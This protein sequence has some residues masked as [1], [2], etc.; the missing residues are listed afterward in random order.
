MFTLKSLITLVGVLALAV[1]VWFAG[2]Y[3]A[4]ADRKILEE[5]WPRLLVI[6]LLLLAWALN[7]LRLW[8]QAKQ[9]NRQLAHG[10]TQQPEGTG[11]DYGEN[12]VAILSSRFREAVE[13]LKRTSGKQKH[14]S[15]NY[16]YELPWY[17]LIGPPGSGKTTALVNSG[18]NF[19]LEEKFGRGAVKGVGGTRHCDWW[20]TD[21]A[22]LIDTAGR[23]TTQDSHS[24]ADAKAWRGF[25]ALLK[26]YR[27]RRPINGVLIAMGIDELRQQTETELATNVNAIRARL[28]ELT[29]TLGV[30]FPV[31]LLL[32]KCD[33]L[34]GFSQYFDML[35]KEERAQV[36]G[37]TL[38]EKLD[39]LQTCHQLF[40]EE[41]DLLARRL[42]DNV[43][44]KFH[45]ERDQRRRAAI[46]DFPA[47]F[48][49]VKNP[50]GEFIGRTF[51]ESRF[52]DR[53][54]LR[55][56]YFT[57]GTQDGN[58]MQ[59]MLNSMAGRMGVQQNA[60][61][62]GSQGQGKSFFIRNLFQQIIFPEAEMVGV[63]RRHESKLRWLQNAG[64]VATLGGAVGMAALWST[65]YGLNEARLRQADEL[66]SDYLAQREQISGNEQPEQMLPP[67]VPLLALRDV[68]APQP[69]DWKLGFGLD[70]G[71]P[72]RD[73]AAVEYQNLLRQDFFHS[74]QNQLAMQLRQNQDQPEYLHQALKAYLMLSLPQ[75]LDK[76][77]VS[78]WL[79]ADWQNRHAQQPERLQTLNT[80][81]DELMAQEWPVQ[82]TDD[83]LVEDTRRILKQ[84]PLARQIY[85]SIKEKARQQ[86][87]LDFRFDTQVGHNIHYVFNGEY[88]PI[89]WLYTTEGYHDFFKPQQANIIEQ[90]ADDS[91][92]VGQR[93]EDM[94]DLDLATVQ[95][96]VEKS[97]LDDYI[98]HWNGAFNRL[99]IKQPTS[100]DDQVR[101]LNELVG[102][103]SPLRRVL[104][105]VSTHTQ[106]SKPLVDTQALAQDAKDA[107]ALAGA[108]NGAAGS[109]INSKVTRLS[110]IA[111]LASR[112][113]LI[114]LPEN[115][116]TLVDT[117]FE[118]IHELMTAKNN[119]P[120]PVERLF[121]A[122][123]EVQRFLEG[124]SSSGSPQ[125]ASYDLAM[126]R[127]ANGRSDPIGN[128]KIEARHLP[129]PVQQWINSLVDR[130]WGHVLGGAGSQ[131]AAEYQNQV[132]PFYERSLEGRYPFR[133]D[134]QVEV[135]LADF[136]EFFKPGGIQDEFF[137]QYVEP[138]VDTKRSPWRSKSVDGQGLGISQSTLAQFEQAAL[139][140]KVFFA[141]GDAPKVDFKL[142]ATYLDANINRFEF[143][144]LGER[145]ENRHGPARESAITWPA[146]GGNDALEYTFEDH[147]GVQFSDQMRGEWALFRFLDRH[148]LGKT[149][150]G[151]RFNLVV[152]N[153]ERK[154]M[155]ELHAG[156]ALNPFARDYLGQ[157]RLPRSL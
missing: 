121:T 76:E 103:D 60:V 136:A 70:Q 155:Y 126:G 64:Y 28:Q 58:G 149:G 9:G 59:R 39:P 73:L 109:A 35:G 54:L 32:T 80:R 61:L 23:Y 69:G 57:S 144:V 113:R 67:F 92:V 13:I 37:M 141:N 50:A 17:I 117:R 89:P 38:P 41:F 137:K 138:F 83:A 36:W 111:T 63:N 5:E 128:L 134:A 62:G 30:N 156:S 79:K 146:S 135:T 52:H 77:F 8:W 42:H 65:S 145:M 21:Q 43:L 48:E 107:G 125:Q 85:V 139:I 110:R 129:Q 53:F 152:Q 22:V 81:L 101:L 90:L 119:A 99:R 46:L 26:K 116:A 71:D 31:Y 104:E 94:S 133:K 2:P 131:M 78:A 120:A 3:I 130:A 108:I 100:L 72:V 45:V 106:L 47:G 86:H 44:G 123:N 55:G 127:M 27:K 34:P 29:D 157:F 19:P 49:Q 122:L 25:I 112:N 56:V 96:A 88:L 93:S 150:Y 154:A 95:A 14:Y 148:P 75:R 12:E 115:P 10:L 87:P 16:L 140:R 151:D 118:P 84:I 7:L 24:S 153:Q 68:F 91:W 15:D 102:G 98:G 114:K 66:V 142:T 97:Y 1:L 11:A 18:L 74:L 20:F 6:A 105:E 4:V 147:Y 40:N 33:L 51:S 143:N 124:V 132:V 82:K